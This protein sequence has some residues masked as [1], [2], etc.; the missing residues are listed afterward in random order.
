MP[1]T[2]KVPDENKQIVNLRSCVVVE[3]IS[4][5]GDR[6]Q[7]EFDLVPDAEADFYS[8]FL[9]ESTPLARAILGQPVGVTV[10]YDQGDITQVR[11]VKS[12]ISKRSGKNAAEERQAELE[13]SIKQIDRT[14]A[15][16]FASTF[17]GK[18]GGY[19]PDAVPKD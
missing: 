19:D 12:C 6:E 1:S 5:S 18:W 13:Q 11:I 9:G 17:D 3:L 7:L 15:M 16:V 4:R 8:G 2:L 10:A 14:N